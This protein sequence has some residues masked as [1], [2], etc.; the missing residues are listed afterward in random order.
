MSFQENI[1]TA[2]FPPRPPNAFFCFRSRFIR[3]KKA[4]AQAEPQG[5]NLKGSRMPDVS[6]EAAT[7][8]NSMTD[9]EQRPFFEMATRLR[10]EHKVLYPNY[11]FA[12]GKKSAAAAS[13]SA[14]PGAR[15]AH[16][17]AHTTKAPR[18]S[19][20]GPSFSSD[21]KAGSQNLIPTLSS[22]YS[23]PHETLHRSHSS[24]YVPQ[25]ME[26]VPNE[27]SADF[28]RFGLAASRH[29]SPDDMFGSSTSSPDD[30]E[31]AHEPS[32]LLFDPSDDFRSFCQ[33]DN[34]FSHSYTAGST[35]GAYYQ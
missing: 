25:G 4:A 8:W 21:G 35:S 10:D 29:H 12:P 32:A 17:R 34:D 22:A 33:W 7:R 5:S 14:V 3:E 20:T 23:P 16:R 6:R 13:K 30:E 9:A 31:A 26:Y 1:P 27:F 11:K 2:N 24:P 19:G 18:T 28:S 15:P